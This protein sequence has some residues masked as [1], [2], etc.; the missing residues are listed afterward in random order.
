MSAL[1][2]RLN[3]GLSLLA[4]GLQINGDHVSLIIIALKQLLYKLLMISFRL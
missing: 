2:Q 3:Q 1:R 4:K